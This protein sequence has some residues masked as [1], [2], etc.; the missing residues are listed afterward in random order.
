MMRAWTKPMRMKRQRK[1]VSFG[2]IS[3]AKHKSW[4]LSDAGNDRA[5]LDDSKLHS[6]DDQVD[7]DV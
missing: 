5:V 3:E 2:D 4:F 7:D 6:L 1:P